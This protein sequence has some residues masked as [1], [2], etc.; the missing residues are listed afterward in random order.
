M[1]DASEQKVVDSVWWTL[2]M[3]FGLVPVFAG[4]DKFLNLLTYW[5]KYLAPP[6]ARL[7]PMS[8]QHFMYV[9][10]LVELVVGLAVLL[11]PWT[12]L[13]AYVVAVWLSCIAINLI[14]GRVFDVAVRDL[15]LAVSALSLARLTEIAP[16]RFGAPARLRPA[17]TAS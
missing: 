14:V 16:V 8:A 6:F 9:V 11:T 2:R 12:K 3:T 7:L 13:F 1:I 10:G 4:I 17:P 5:P 15:V